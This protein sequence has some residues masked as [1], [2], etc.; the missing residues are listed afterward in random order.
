MDHS[1]YFTGERHFGFRP[2]GDAGTSARVT[3][4]GRS[5][6]RMDGY[7]ILKCRKITPEEYRSRRDEYLHEASPLG[8]RVGSNSPMEILNRICVIDQKLHFFEDPMSD[9]D[10]V[11]LFVQAPMKVNLSGGGLRFNSKDSVQ[12]R[13][14]IDMK[15]VLPTLPFFVTQAVGEVVRVGGLPEGDSLLHEPS[16][17]VAAKFVAI[18][19]ES[20]EAVIGCVFKWQRRVLRERKLRRQA[21]RS[22]YDLH[23]K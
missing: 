7:I 1:E 16:N 12:T 22:S 23:S 2:A 6:V 18:G 3:E 13:D 14:F 11:D 8:D 19:E 20:R 5:H 21:Q 4:S 10:R 9:S 15:M 17:C